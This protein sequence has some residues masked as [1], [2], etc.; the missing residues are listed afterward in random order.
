MESLY[1]N[2]N[3]FPDSFT[4]KSEMV[5][6]ISKYHSEIGKHYKITESRQK[7]Y[8]ITCVDRVLCSFRINYNYINNEFRISNHLTEKHLNCSNLGHKNCRCYSKYVKSMALCLNRKQKSIGTITNSINRLN[9]MNIPYSNIYYKLNCSKKGKLLDLENLQRTVL[10]ADPD[11]I[12]KIKYKDSI[13]QSVLYLDGLWKRIFPYLRKLLFL[14]ATHLFSNMKGIL[15][16]VTALNPNNHI[17]LL[18]IS[19]AAIFRN[20][21]F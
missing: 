6:F 20:L 1:K 7:K 15:Y 19:K 12:F 17:I 3:R 5:T 10:E 13:F 9:N 11:T 8:Y 14:D 4:T 18:G 21:H 16:T 2:E